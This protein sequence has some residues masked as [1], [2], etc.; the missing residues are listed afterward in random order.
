MLKLILGRSGT[1]K[2]TAVLT[3]L[4]EAGQ[5]RKQVLIV[6]EQQSHEMERALCRA[7]GDRVSLYAEVLSF[8]RLANRVFLATGGMGEPELDAGGR[9]LLMHQAVKAVS[10]QL[11]VYARPSRRPAFLESLLATADELKSSCVQ[12]ELLLQA[13]HELT[14]PEGEKLRDLGLICG[15]YQ[16]M[17]ARTALDPRDRLTRTAEKLKEYPWAQ[18]MDLW[19]DGFTDFTP[20]QREV[21]RHLL[22]QADSLTV[23]LTC[24]HLEEDEGGAG[25]FSPARR[26]AAGLLRLA[27]QEGISCEV[28]HLVPDWDK[29]C[30]PLQQVEKQLFAQGEAEP[31][32]CQGRV[33][34]LGALTPRSEVEQAAAGIRRLIRTQGLRCRDIGVTARD[35]S[36]YQPL[37]EAIFPRYQ[38]PVFTS[39]MTDILEKPI[40]T[41]VTAALDTVADGYRY[42][43]VFRYL[44]TGLTDLPEEDRDLLE[45]YVL[46]WNLRG[47]HWTQ[48]KPWAMPPKGYGA[49]VTNEDRALLERLDHARR[50]VAEP[51]ELLR[52]NQNRTGVGQA[53]C[54]YSFMEEIGLPQRLEDRVA[55]LHRRDQPALAEEYRQLWEILCR[56]LE[57]CAALLGETPME[58]EEFSGLFRL[59]LSQYDV[60]TIPVSLDRVTVGETTRETGH[61]VKVL[62]LLGADDVSIPKAGSAPG[63]LSDEDRSFLAGY[64]LELAQSAQE[65]LYREMTTVYLTCARP[66]ER[67]VVSWPS[68]SASGEERR[69]S[70]LVER[71]RRLF[72]DLRVTREEDCGGTF[73]LEAPLP[74]LE[75]AGR[76]PAARRALSALPE[77][78]PMVERL[79]RA[80]GW[81]R[82]RLSRLAVDRLYGRKVSM[83]ASRMDKYKSCHF[84]YFM[85]Y[86]LQ[87]EP[88]KPAG[89]TAP[90][91]GTFVHDVLEHVLRDEMFQQTVLPGFSD[92]IAGAEGRRRLRELTR[93][94]VDRYVVEELGGLEHQTE[95]FR[96]LFRRLLRSVQAVVD[97]VAEELAASQFRPISFELGFGS[98]QD[99]PPVE[100]TVDGVTISVT[101]F[102]DRV[103]GWVHDGRLY[104]RVVDYKTGKKSFDLTEVW[105]GLGLQMLLYLFA[106]EARGPDYY[107]QPVEGAGV[108]YL[109]A[110]DAVVKGSRAMTDEAWRKQ[111]DRELTRSGLVLDDAAVLSAMEEPG[112]QGYRFLPLK[113]SKATGA[114]S[115][116][117]LA[118]AERLGKLGGHLQR[119]LEE[120][121][122]ELAEGNIAADP[123]WRGPEKNAC[124][125]CDYAA[126]CLFE[127][128]RG[129]DCRRWL[130]SVKSRDFW[131]QLEEEPDGE[132]EA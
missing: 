25:I 108:L 103:D 89:F 16:A 98:G 119:T 118:S 29:R 84:S 36:V 121:C 4:T 75:Q 21:L 32:S 81:S 71:L 54:L 79:D 2:T 14:G 42:D 10:D 95:R 30:E 70:F 6:P 116:E 62:F 55:E 1:G 66:S 102:V 80:A 3:R 48:K 96:Y 19:L 47:S 68:Q 86:G 61:P 51:L 85:R 59:V 127:A 88:R 67:L 112:E 99:L 113:V 105:N 93:A 125:F 9:L 129:G 106:L 76:N 97:N 39:A 77:Y 82:G 58:L 24:D 104:L 56:G 46:K 107:G 69:P 22:R 23:T 7:G 132:D 8:S 5:R 131:K 44:K 43:D 126:A 65:L 120:I 117:A 13:G 60:G 64:G 40:L 38:I 109:P 49:A 114:I 92:P 11:T 27:G 83:S 57:Q 33:E 91:Y 115:G 26:T 123:F 128:G 20:Q 63:L 94:A 111:L 52:K 72:T 130:P 45:N 74:A 31:V 78:A 73:R 35:L 90:E 17:T 110:R 122:R 18:G 37:I 53:I 15:T 41:L 28:E 100:L 101:G 12:P 124:R 50:Q 87:A 34:L